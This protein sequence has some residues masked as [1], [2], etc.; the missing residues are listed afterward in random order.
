M[1]Q[2]KRCWSSAEPGVLFA[3]WSI[4]GEKQAS[5]LGLVLHHKV[6]ENIIDT[7]K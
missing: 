1:G 5:G 2:L 4:L 6:V 3:T 7:K